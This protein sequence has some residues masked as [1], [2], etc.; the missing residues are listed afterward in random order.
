MSRLW[1]TFD[2]LVVQRPLF[3]TRISRM[4]LHKFRFVSQAQHVFS[5]RVKWG[6][7]LTRILHTYCLPNFAFLR[8]HATNNSIN[9]VAFLLLG[10][11]D[12]ACFRSVL[13]RSLFSLYIYVQWAFAH[14]AHIVSA[15]WK[16][17]PFLSTLHGTIVQCCGYLLHESLYMVNPKAMWWVCA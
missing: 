8:M 3:T 12:G 17:F 6:P 4:I 10:L 15:I 1:E 2:T 13:L 11:C 7:C 5:V 14:R 9:I 16:W